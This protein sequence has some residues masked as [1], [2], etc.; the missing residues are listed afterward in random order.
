MPPNLTAPTRFAKPH[1][2]S[3][4]PDGGASVPTSRPDD[5]AVGVG[6]GIGV[7]PQ[8][9]DSSSQSW[10]LATLSGPRLVTTTPE[11][12]QP[13]ARGAKRPRVP[14][15]IS[16]STLARVAAGALFLD[17]RRGSGSRAP[18]QT[19][20]FA[21]LPGYESTFSRL[22]RV[23]ADA[24]IRGYRLQ[25]LRRTRRGRRHPVPVFNGG[26]IGMRPN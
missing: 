22:P 8:S 16:T 6:I 7:E 23:G 1:P 20:H 14:R 2:P 26:R 25:R 13:V 10:H 15:P 18:P 24:P 17:S 21:P 5:L 11:A 12:F 3:P 4:F 19:G 9:P